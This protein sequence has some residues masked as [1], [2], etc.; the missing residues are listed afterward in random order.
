MRRAVASASASCSRSASASTSVASSFSSSSLVSKLS[1]LSLRRLY[2]G[3]GSATFGSAERRSI[4]DGND[5]FYDRCGGWN[6]NNNNNNNNNN[7]FSAMMTAS[8]K[9]GKRSVATTTTTK[10]T[11]ETTGLRRRI[12]TQNEGLVGKRSASS[13][14][15]F[16][17][18]RSYSESATTMGKSDDEGASPAAAR[19]PSSSSSS[20]SSSSTSSSSSSSPT[21][22]A[23][24][25]TRV[26]ETRVYYPGQTYD[27]SEL[28]GSFASA[29]PSAS[30]KTRRVLKKGK[31]LDALV[32]RSIDWK[33]AKMLSTR[34]VSETGKI[35]PR[36]QTGLGAKTHRLVVKNI[37]IARIMG[38]LPFT[39][40]L[41]QFA[42]RRKNPYS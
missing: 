2:S 14:T 33:D 37:K 22:T 28:E 25:T 41:P 13:A 3:G 19:Q 30:Q 35:V 17:S 29:A 6:D 8:K 20:S 4:I 40:R 16:F 31:D 38:V 5:S 9:V 26:S 36:R 32:A 12:E 1:L 27:P 42:R 7:R 21:P 18:E 11:T 10:T 15:F 23:R 39:D 24:P 34:F